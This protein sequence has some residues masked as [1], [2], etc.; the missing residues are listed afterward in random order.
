MVYRFRS[1]AVLALL[2]LGLVAFHPPPAPPVSLIVVITID[3]LRPDY[4]T[5]WGGQW[6]GGFHRLLTEGAVFPNGLQDHA[7]T[8]TAP[9]HATILSGRYPAHTGIPMNDLGVPD[10]TVR[11]LGVQHGPG[12]SPR[13]FLGTTLVD[14]LKRDDPGLRFL[15][16]SRKDRGAILPIGRARGPVFWFAEGRFTTSTYYGDT[17]PGWV[18]EWTARRGPERLEGT[19]W[20]LI[21]PDSAYAERDDQ[22]WEHGGRQTTFPHPIPAD[23]AG[24]VATLPDRPWMDSLT[25]D[26]ALTG[27][28]ALGLGSRGR[29]DLLAVSL[30]STDYIGHEWGPDSREVHDHLLRLDRWL[31]AFLD[32]LAALARRDRILVVLTADHGVT[33]FPELALAAG[34]P[35]GRIALNRL[36]QGVNRAVGGALR[37]SSGLIYAD[38][39]RLRAAR[40]NP[41]SLA[42]AL[43]AQVQKLP[44]VVD[45]WTPA[46]LGAPLP[47]NVGA[48][49]WRRALPPTLPWLVSAQAAPGYIW[50]DG[51]GSTTHGTTNPDDVNVPIAFLGAGIRPGIFP[52]TVTTVDI[53]PTLARLLGLKPGEKLDG[54]AIKRLFK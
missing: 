46:T 36:V 15:S 14:W 26:F 49:R 16:V 44:G 39:A 30:S 19:N 5:R 27:A 48:S 40:V 43:V 31:G 32:T 42:T 37:E 50:S 21:L 17:L 6:S 24:A 9:G 4:L 54:R 28:R 29:P 52:D 20:T 22:P 33:P 13:R 34:R 45:A 23:S 7:I 25:L 11:L 2:A 3:Q 41:E 18:T 8:E 35:A 1:V 47:S 53:A 10:S 38:T 12:A 51:P